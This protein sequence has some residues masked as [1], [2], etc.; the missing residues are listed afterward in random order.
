MDLPLRSFEHFESGAGR[1]NLSR[2]QS[3]AKATNSDPL[4]ILLAVWFQAPALAIEAADNKAAMIFSLALKDL[5]EAAGQDLAQLDARTL[6]SAFDQ[7]VVALGDEA[8]ARGDRARRWIG[9][10]T[11]PPDRAED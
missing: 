5:H 2:I 8:R 10:R 3:F 1:L 7:L 9:S 6:I 11:D 4:A